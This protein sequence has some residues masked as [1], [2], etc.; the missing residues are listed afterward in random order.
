MNRMF[1]IL[2]S[3]GT[4]AASAV[5]AREPRFH[6]HDKGFVPFQASQLD[7]RF[8]YM[9]YVPK[10]YDEKAEKSYPLIVLIHGTERAPHVYLEKNADF[11]EKNDVILLAPLF[12][13]GTH[14]G[15]DLENY[16]LIEYKGTR[17]DLILLS[18]VDEA[19]AKYRI[20]DNKFSLF[21]FSG[22]GH[23]AHRFFYLH[24]HRLDAIS[25]GAPGMVTLI[26]DSRDWW[27]GTRDLYW[28]FNARLNPK[29]MQ[30]VKVQMMVGEEDTDRW[31][32]EIE[33]GS[34]YRMPD[35]PGASYN[36]AGNDRIERL[37]TLRD[38]FK[39]HGIDVQFDLIPEAGHDETQMF[40][41][42][43]KFFQKHLEAS[44]SSNAD[45]AKSDTEGAED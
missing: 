23:F 24:P 14:G 4:F 41:T 45:P 33:K 13:V 11:A 31:E 20:E 3:L 18:M 19:M 12:P 15:K 5:D 7:P 38:N 8:S 27:V 32:D 44:R 9:M 16:K 34:P 39:E 36:A 22:G 6:W 37:K 30:S 42:M 10:D 21:G 25:I 35:T 1:A 28:R 40:P 43:Q 17:Y 26:D 2:L 29:A